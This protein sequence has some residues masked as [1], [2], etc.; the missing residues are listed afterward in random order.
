LVRRPAVGALIRERREQIRR[1]QMDVALDVGV[2][3]RHLSY[4]ELGKS[5]PSPELL[6]L[7]ATRL[8]IGLR[9]RNEW[10]LAAG[11]A[12]RHPETPLQDDAL[13]AVASSLQALL[14]AHNPMPGCVIDRRWTVQLSNRAANQL[15]D[16]IPDYARDVPSNIFRISLH[17]DGFAS[18]TLNFEEWSAYLLWELDAAIARTRE[19]DLVELAAEIETWPRIPP[20]EEWGRRDVDHDAGYPVVTWRVQAHGHEFAFF[21]TLSVFAAPLDVTLSE[22]AI[23]LFFPADRHTRVALDAMAAQPYLPGVRQSTST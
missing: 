20:R 22:L 6:E 14:D 12:P 16:G 23:E 19:P 9:E 11:Y 2:S 4:V 1:S 13:G 3:P 7:I 5:R 10:L 8:G 18:R 17:P 21:T 15:A